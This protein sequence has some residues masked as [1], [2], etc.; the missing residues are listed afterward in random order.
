MISSSWITGRGISSS[1]A[2]R[3]CSCAI[4]SGERVR[5]VAAKR[6]DIPHLRTADDTAA[7]D[8]TGG[9]RFEQRVEVQH[10]AGVD[11]H[12][13]VGLCRETKKNDPPRPV[14]TKKS[15]KKSAVEVRA[16]PVC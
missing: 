1:P 6:G 9:A 13:P 3:S 14:K 16:V 4:A 2:N 5:D 7:F 12:F 8:K 11:G 10:L 15:S